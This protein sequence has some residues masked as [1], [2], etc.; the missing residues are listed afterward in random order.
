LSVGL[1]RLGGALLAGDGSLGGG[2]LALGLI[3]VRE[4]DHGCRN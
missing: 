2:G 3:A 4:K 1:R